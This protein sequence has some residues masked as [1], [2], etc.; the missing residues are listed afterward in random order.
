MKKQ[1]ILVLISLFCFTEY[2]NS[3]CP[4][5]N[6]NKDKYCIKDIIVS[7]SADG[8]W[9]SGY[10]VNL[11]YST[12][13]DAMDGKPGLAIFIQTGDG[14]FISKVIRPDDDTPIKIPYQYATTNVYQAVAEVT[15]IYDGG[16]PR[17]SAPQML[18]AKS[19]TPGAPITDNSSFLLAFPGE[20]VEDDLVT[21]VVNYKSI[22]LTSHLILMFDKTVFD[23]DNFMPG[24]DMRMSYLGSEGNYGKLEIKNTGTVPNLFIRVRPG[25]GLALNQQTTIYLFKDS[26]LYH[27]KEAPL[28]NISLA[29]LTSHD[30][31]N[32]TVEFCKACISRRCTYP[33]RSSVRNSQ[34]AAPFRVNFENTGQG[35]ETNVNVKFFFSLSTLQNTGTL[36]NPVYAGR[37]YAPTGDRQMS[38][39]TRTLVP[40]PEAG[41]TTFS[42]EGELKGTNSIPYGHPSTRG[43]IGFNT[44]TIKRLRD[45]QPEDTITAW[46]EINFVKAIE[47]IRT[48]VIKFTVKEYK[49]YYNKHCICQYKCFLKRWICRLFRKIR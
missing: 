44:Q 20:I 2:V 45:L 31:N 23:P 19:S 28:A 33:S 18:S 5:Y 9:I 14:N 25:K 42:F 46:G 43:A 15:K 13:A 36:H 27:K 1:F 7:Y 24:P 17:R 39:A 37:T 10:S 29:V 6:G 38:P 32:I 12:D 22:P 34:I 40:E 30:P 16:G 21:L 48:N 8:F 47:T 35:D 49:D 3:Q 26:S 11:N 41:T 4:G